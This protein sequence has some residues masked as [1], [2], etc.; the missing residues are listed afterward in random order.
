MIYTLINYSFLSTIQVYVEFIKRTKR[1]ECYTKVL[2]WLGNSTNLCD[3][4]VS[5]GK[6][7]VAVLG[8]CAGVNIVLMLSYSFQN[9]LVTGRQLK[10]VTRTKL[11]KDDITLQKRLNYCSGNRSMELVN[12]DWDFKKHV[13]KAFCL[14]MVY[15]V[16][17]TGPKVFG[18]RSPS[19]IDEFTNYYT[20]CYRFLANFDIA[21]S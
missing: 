7:T 9:V 2:G 19:S 16:I 11:T 1:I 4:M 10:T 20:T 13:S 3:S 17:I 15:G 12:S 21:I 5:C 14:Y 18:W 8:A 6:V